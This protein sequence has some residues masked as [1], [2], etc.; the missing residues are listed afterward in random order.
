MTGSP[1]AS[2]C[3]KCG[4]RAPIVLRG[5][6]SRCAA[7]GAPRSLLAAPNVSFAGQP[8]RLGGVA[9][10]IAGVSVLVLGLSL[11]AGLWFLLQSIWPTHA[12]GWA[13]ALPMGAASLLFGFLLLLGGSRLRRRGTARQQEVQLEAVKS[14]VAHRRGPISASEVAGSLQLPEEQVDALLTRLAREQATAVTL[15]VDAHGRIV[16]DFEGEERRW[17]VLEEAAQG[18]EAEAEQAREQ[19]RRR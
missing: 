8:S 9:A 13:F 11:S 1:F 4:R 6:D 7:C 16:Y 5:L 10:T 2:Q 18:Q 17:R 19:A 15:D 14:M 3:S 12:V